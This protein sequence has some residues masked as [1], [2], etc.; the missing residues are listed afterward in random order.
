MP[1]PNATLSLLAV[2]KIVEGTSTYTG[3]E[4]FRMLVKNLAETLDLHGVW[5]TESIKKKTTSAHLPSG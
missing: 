3:K 4:F 2:K 1:S 5:V